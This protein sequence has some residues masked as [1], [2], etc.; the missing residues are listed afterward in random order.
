MADLVA[1]DQ[2][3][4]PVFVD[5][6]RR[7]WDAGD[8]VFPVDQRLPVNARNALIATM[9]PGWVV[10]SDGERRRLERGRPVEPGDALVVATSGTGGEPKGVVLTHAAVEDSAVATSSRLGVEPPRDRWFACL[11]V[12]H[13][14]GL[15]VVTRAI[16]TGTP[17][18]VAAAP[19]AEALDAAARSGCTLASLVYAVLDRVDATRWR[20]L[21]LGGSRPPS[22]K[23]LPEN[24]FTTYG[25]TESGSGVVYDGLPLDGVEVRLG[26]D[27][28]VHLR[29]P[30][31]LRCYRDGTDPK[32]TDGWF[33]TGDLGAI[34]VNGR[35][36]VHGRRGDVIVTGGEKV[37]PEIVE[38]VL[39][40]TR[41]VAEV[42]VAGR[43]DDAWGQRVV[44]YVVPVDRARPP[45]LEAL[46]EKV[47]TELPAWCAPRE[48]VLVSSL[49]RTALGKVRR[50]TLRWIDQG[51][52]SLPK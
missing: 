4:S 37:W 39:A 17:L 38:G 6:L 48:V 18:E 27:G 41:G 29:G 45:T 50:G 5:T 36:T 26:D 46:R 44:A 1:L 13:I 2:P 31:L 25:M 21:V 43:D 23:A 32:D 16:A 42:A 19:S 9:A 49:P 33:A 8:A 28:E 11:P 3:A 52:Q 34:D 20:A 15:A 51:G 7:I 14:G 35:L 30:M 40:G 12:A 47:K 22:M 10:G 24:V